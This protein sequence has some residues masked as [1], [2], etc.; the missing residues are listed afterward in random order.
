M[1]TTSEPASEVQKPR[2]VRAVEA[3]FRGAWE[4]GLVYGL[5]AIS[6][7]LALWPLTDI[8]AVR[9]IVKNDLSVPQR[10]QVLLA[11]T[12]STVVTTVTYLLVWLRARRKEPGL[13]VGESFRRTNRWAYIAML[14]PMITALAVVRIETKHPNFTGFLLVLF[15][16]M[17]MTFIYKVLPR[18][19]PPDYEPFKPAARPKLAFGVFVAVLLGY[20]GLIGAY[21]LIDH[22]N[23]GTAIYDL[24]IYDNLVWQTAHG[25]FLDCTLIKGGNHISAHFDPILAVIAVIYRVYQHAETLLVL[26]TVWLAS[27][28]IPL[29]LLTRRRLKNEWFAALLALVY[30]M[31]PALHGVNMFDF[32]SLAFI[33]PNV[34]WAVYLLDTGG[35]KRYWLVLAMLL[36]TREDISLLSCFIGAYAILTG[37]TRTGLLTILVSVTYLVLV[38]MFAMADS[39][40]LMASKSSYSYVYYYDDMIPHSKEGVRG[41]V[42]TTLV[43]PLYAIQVAFKEEKLI[44]FLHL[45]LPLLCLPFASGRKLILSVYGLIF[46]G[47]ASRKHV[48]SLHFQYS[49]LL[50]PALFVSIPD[51]FARVVDSRR[52][53]ALGLER[54]RLAWTLM[55]GMLTATTVTTVKYGVIFPNA[56]FKS[57]WNRLVRVPSQDMVDRYARVQ[58]LVARV[59]P[60]AAVS[61]TS[62]VGPHFSNRRKA[63]HWPTVNDADYLVLGTRNFK[64]DDEKKIKRLRDR[65]QFRLVDEAEGIALY[66][67]IEDVDV[68]AEGDEPEE[69]T[70][71]K[72]APKPRTPSVG[73]STTTTTPAKTAPV[74]DAADAADDEAPAATPVPPGKTSS[75]KAV[76]TTRP[77]PGGTS[78]RPT[79]NPT[80]GPVKPTGTPKKKSADE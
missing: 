57:G 78:T 69:K 11:V 77:V 31:Y 71:R 70:K 18:W 68:D 51:G 14:A 63:Y 75:G 74:A 7:G 33:V 22:R 59:G 52:L 67:R 28:M 13:G 73:K 2:W 79:A 30:A 27:G 38:K 48:F 25:N 44:F 5:I 3:L 53:R 62:E 29:Y 54:G 61:L 50:F 35:F 76:T 32:H 26:Q 9:Y 20:T 8:D 55:L 17:A 21:T 34:M 6:L 37:R 49:A 42:I 4:W 10:Y 36:I 24:G 43:N 58:E 15:T 1:S 64:K 65:K 46:I 40:L 72:P 47:L 80:G 45:F 56:S 12:I 60:D 19:L 23:L 39:S 41:L 16:V 66:E